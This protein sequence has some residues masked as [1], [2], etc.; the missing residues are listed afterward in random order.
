MDISVELV[1]A[2]LLT[3]PSPLRPAAFHILLALAE[4]DLHG[5]GIA[6]SVESASGGTTVLGPGT[7]YRSL[8]EMCASGLIV[9]VPAP[10]E[11]DTRR[12]Y[13]R[14]TALG[15]SCLADEIRR[16]DQLVSLARDRRV[17]EPTS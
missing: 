15:R 14:A 7:L 11:A 4:D 5:L 1:G 16:L 3:A 8:K 13:Y 9:E 10:A 6:D 17:V 12:R 2:T